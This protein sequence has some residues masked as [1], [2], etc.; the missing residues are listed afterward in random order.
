VADRERCSFISQSHKRMKAKRTA[1]ASLFLDHEW[2]N[3]MHALG[4][5]VNVWNRR[6]GRSASRVLA[7]LTAVGLVC[8][9]VWLSAGRSAAQS[10]PSRSLIDQSGTIVVNDEAFFPFGFYGISWRQ[11]IEERKNAVRLLGAAGI[12]T[13][14]A[15]DIS[16]NNFGELLDEASAQGMKVLVGSSSLPDN[17]YIGATIDKYASHPAV[18]GWSLFDDADDGTVSA[19]QVKERNDFV[20]NKDASHFT[21]VPLTGYYSDRRVGRD[22][23]IATTDASSVQMYPVTPLSDYSFD[24]DGN[25]LA[26]S[27]RRTRA[28]VVSG[29]RQGKAVLANAQTFKWTS[30]GSRYPSVPELRNMV[31]GQVMAG[32]KGILSYDFSFDLYNEQRPLFDEYASIGNDI[33][34]LKEPILNGQRTVN[35]SDADV[36]V[37]TWAHNDSFIVGIVNTSTTSAKALDVAMPTGAADAMAP[38]VGR[39]SNTMRL[40]NGRMLG[41]IAPMDVQIYRV[42]GSSADTTPTPVPTSSPV[43]VS[44]SSSATVSTSSP[45]AG[46]LGDVS[47]NGR[48]LRYDFFPNTDFSG[49]PTFSDIDETVNYDWG[50]ESPSPNLPFDNFSVRWA[51]QIESPVDGAV[52]FSIVADGGARLWIDNEVVIDTLADN[53]STDTSRSYSL[54]AGQRVNVRMDFVETTGAAVAKLQWT[55]SGQQR[56]IIPKAFLYPDTSVT[57]SSSTP[58]TPTTAATASTSTPTVVVPETSPPTTASTTAVTTQSSTSSTLSG[59]PTSAVSG[60]SQTMSYAV[61]NENFANPE[62]GFAFEND[63]PW[64]PNDTWDFCRQ[65]NNFTAYNYDAWNTPLDGAFLAAERAQGRSVV[66]SRYHIAAFRNGDISPEYIAFLD[67]DFATARAAGMKQIIRFAY[68]YPRGGPDAPLERVLRH[69]DQLKPVLQRNKDV[70]ATMEAG[71][72]GCWGEWNSSS[73]ELLPRNYPPI[74]DRDGYINEAS[75]QILEKLLDT[76]PRDRMLQMRYPRNFFEY[77]G[78]TDLSPPAPLTAETAYNGSPL[79]RVGYQDDCF[80]CNPLHGGSY[81]NPRGAFEETP[82]FLRANNEFVAQG[83]E[84]GDP[85]STD[86]REPANPNSPLSSC[87]AVRQEFSTIHWSTV[88]LYNINSPASAIKRW[89]RDG[90][91]DEFNR[92]LGYRFVLKS[93]TLPTVA[94]PG[95]SIN[96]SLVMTNEGY[97]RPYNP[98]SIELVLRNTSNGAVVRRQINPGVDE[99]LWLPGPNETKTLSA[100]V[101]LPTDLASGAYDMLLNFPDPEPSINNRADFS[102]RLANADT[103]ESA[104]GYND[105][106]STVTIG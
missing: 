98:R 72:I 63:V 70:I 22:A 33:D 88:G 41:T 57:P 94:Q 25:P 91:W 27:Y 80:V 47:A 104:T 71:F 51:G 37:T 18:L 15:E 69:L 62:R 6:F 49:T 100:S 26:E 46:D 65:G 99:R 89:Q 7:A 52:T 106:R 90:C 105:L 28:Y 23:F 97:A 17:Q 92:N 35:D 32:A 84:P 1:C 16:T 9:M 10:S 13:V 5:L 95:A 77:L 38:A 85:E 30:A 19:G 4:R 21:Y 82:N 83:G 56:S 93:V 64:A 8:S 39:L 54:A 103:W 3:H 59:P 60:P 78:S 43:T 42:A 24:G 87:D 74:S 79:S 48:G 73:N 45:V 34:S 29:E 102:I 101:S 96:L 14:V 40:V 44:T 75:R 53:A 50:T 68:N 55:Y 76:L 66:M 67:R 12:N 61:S 20:K 86:P 58:S 81:W 36:V 2:E 31:F 11:P